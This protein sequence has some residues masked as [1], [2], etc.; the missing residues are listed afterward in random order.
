PHAAR[1]AAILRD[2]VATGLLLN[3]WGPGNLLLQVA[4]GRLAVRLV[5]ALGGALPTW[6]ALE[7]WLAV[8][9]DDVLTAD[10]GPVPFPAGRLQ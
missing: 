2:A 8:D 3:V 7:D 4:A 1:A 10:P 9:A 5:E 6:S